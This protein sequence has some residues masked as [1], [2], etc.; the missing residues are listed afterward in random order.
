MGH[1]MEIYTQTF[2]A[3]EGFVELKT[4]FLIDCFTNYT[5]WIDN[6]WLLSW[7]HQ[8]T[9]NI[10]NVKFWFTNSIPIIQKSIYSP[11]YTVNIRLQIA[12]WHSQLALHKINISNSQLPH[13]LSKYWRSF[14]LNFRLF[15]YWSITHC[16]MYMHTCIVLLLSRFFT[17]K[18]FKHP[19]IRVSFLI[20]LQYTFNWFDSMAFATQYASIHSETV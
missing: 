10:N 18:T 9:L 17:N 7:M 19:V 12:T 16:P 8:R 14:W 20:F 13:G 2:I 1:R 5:G 4:K 6:N 3:Y 15:K 11:M